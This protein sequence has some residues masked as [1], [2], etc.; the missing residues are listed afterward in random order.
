[1]AATQFILSYIHGLQRL[2]EFRTKLKMGLEKV[3]YESLTWLP[4]PDWLIWESKKLLTSQESALNY[5]ETSQKKHSSSS[6]GENDGGGQSRMCRLVWNDRKCSSDSNNRPIQPRYAEGTRTHQTGEL[7]ATLSNEIRRHKVNIFFLKFIYLFFAWSDEP[8]LMMRSLDHPRV[9][10]SSN[11]T[12]N[13]SITTIH[14]LKPD[15]NW[16]CQ[17]LNICFHKC[18]I[19]VLFG[20]FYKWHI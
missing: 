2:L 12:N 6:L 4:V 17:A 10:D 8:R 3:I 18:L 1:M 7:W 20:D 5:L 16:G 14:Q 9:R 15:N 13:K 19:T 11:Y